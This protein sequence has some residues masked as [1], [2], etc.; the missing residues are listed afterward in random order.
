M[1]LDRD[2]YCQVDPGGANKQRKLVQSPVLNNYHCTPVESKVFLV[3][4]SVRIGLLVAVVGMSAFAQ[5]AAPNPT[6]GVP[7]GNVVLVSLFKP[8][9]PSLARQADISGEVKVAVT[10]HQDGKTTAAIQS[11]HAMLRQAALD[12]AKQSRFECRMCATPLSYSLVYAFELT[13]KGDCCNAFSSPTEVTQEPESIS[14][15]RQPQTRVTVMS[16]HICLCD[17]SA[18]MTKRVRSLKCLYLWKC[19]VK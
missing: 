19:S 17:P 11:G 18:T 10:V 2:N 12:S 4:Y 15:E 9:Y 7:K 5:Q 8:V 1:L 13:R 3:T 6:S 16:R 14:N